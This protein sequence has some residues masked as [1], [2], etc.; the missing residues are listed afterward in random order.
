MVKLKQW[1]GCSFVPV[2]C[3]CV[4]VHRCCLSFHSLLTLVTQLQSFLMRICNYVAL[5]RYNYSLYCLDFDPNSALWNTWKATEEKINTHISALSQQTQLFHQA[6]ITPLCL[7][8]LGQTNPA[9]Q[10]SGEF[11]LNSAIQALI[12]SSKIA[13]VGCELWCWCILIKIPCLWK[14]QPKLTSV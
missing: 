11:M 2:E 5:K 3:L 8:C 13:L 9:G 12:W 10:C 14:C 1:L 6:H 4:C 7:D